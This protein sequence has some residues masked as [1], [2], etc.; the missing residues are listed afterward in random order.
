MAWI[1]WKKPF[2]HGFRPL[3][4]RNPGKSLNAQGF[5]PAVAQILGKVLRRNEDALRTRIES[6]SIQEA[7]GA[8]HGVLRDPAKF[9]TVPVVDTWLP[10]GEQLPSAVRELFGLYSSIEVVAGEARLSQDL[11]SAS[12]FHPGWIRI[13]TDIDFTEIAVR[14]GDEGVYE[15]DG[16]ES[17]Q[18]DF[19]Q[20]CSSSVYH[21]IVMTAENLYGA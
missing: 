4:L 16:S 20:A 6:M 11:I 3:P 1:F 10:Q 14:P 7:R 18:K 8:A 21:W 9:R 17:T 2:Y 15:F 19:D 13:G 12:E 5:S